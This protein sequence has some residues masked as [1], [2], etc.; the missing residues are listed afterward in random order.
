MNK[1]IVAVA[2]LVMA[3][4]ISACAGASPTPT[5]TPTPEPTPTPTPTVV[6]T[7]PPESA[8]EPYYQ[9]LEALEAYTAT[10]LMQYEPAEGSDQAPFEVFFSEERVKGELPRQR[11]YVRGLSSVDPNVT[12]D[13]ATYVF[14]G[15]ETWFRSGDERFYTTRPNQRRLFLSPEDMIPSTAE[16]SSQG[17]YDRPINGVAVE[18]FTIANPDTLFTDSA[19]EPENPELLQGDVWIAQEG[20][21]IVRYVLRIQADDL[22]LR[23]DPTPGVL[24]IEYNVTAVAPDALDIQPPEDRLTLSEVV[25][26]G[27]EPGTFPYPEGAEPETL[28]Q[29]R[30]QQMVVLNVR[31]MSLD[32]VVAFYEEALKAAGWVENE[33]DRQV[34]E[35]TFVGTTWEKNGDFLVLMIRAGQDTVQIIASN[36]PA[37]AI[38]E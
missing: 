14:I 21:Y 28:V 1:Y 11:V 32:D 7:P 35:G 9:A 31:E 4:I 6:P 20:Q 8:L 17:P 19:S 5:P 23:S 36:R 13:E 10:L 12:R 34:V 15:D 29:T 30:S 33:I 18:Y 3:V 22:K 27:F 25:L 16:L 2:A 24:T 37:P 38:A 26:P